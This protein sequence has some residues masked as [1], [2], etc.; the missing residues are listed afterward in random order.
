[1]FNVSDHQLGRAE[2]FDNAGPYLLCQ[3]SNVSAASSWCQAARAWSTAT[4]TMRCCAPVVVGVGSGERLSGRL[5][6]RLQPDQ[7]RWAITSGS[8]NVATFVFTS[9]HNAK[10][11]Y[12]G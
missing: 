8:Q 10:R 9:R 7:L 11:D 4:R 5:C 3:D 12:V 6:S 1:M 2:V